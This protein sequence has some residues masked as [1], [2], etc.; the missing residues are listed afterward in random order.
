M[1]TS[2][3]NKVSQVVRR[4]KAFPGVQEPALDW[5]LYLDFHVVPLCP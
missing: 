2:Y 5:S 4:T 1:H 3:N